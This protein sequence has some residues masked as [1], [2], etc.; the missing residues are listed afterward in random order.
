LN[1]TRISS[2]NAAASI[3]LV[4][5]SIIKINCQTFFRCFFKNLQIF[6]QGLDFF[7]RWSV[8]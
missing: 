6:F 1:Y 7:S 8:F 2:L 3:A 5:N 4:Y